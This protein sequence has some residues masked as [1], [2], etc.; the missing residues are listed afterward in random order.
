MID[1]AYVPYL[2]RKDR[3]EYFR[4]EIAGLQKALTRPQY[5]F[6]EHPEKIVVDATKF[7]WN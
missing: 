7:T 5:K 2:S 6:T 4:L 1:E 3:E